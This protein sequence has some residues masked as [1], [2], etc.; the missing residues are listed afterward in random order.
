M[1]IDSIKTVLLCTRAMLFKTPRRRILTVVALGL[2]VVPA[3]GYAVRLALWTLPIFGDRSMTAPKLDAITSGTGVTYFHD[4]IRRVPWSIHVVKVERGR[5][6][7]AIDTTLGRA[8]R[9][10]MAT[11]SDQVASVPPEWGKPVAAINGDLY[12]NHPD[13]LGDPEGLQ[14]THGELVSGP[15]SNRVCFWLDAAGLPHRSNVVSRFEAIWP[16]GREVSLGLNQARSDDSAV[17][18][19]SVVGDS[20]RTRGGVELVLE[21]MGPEQWLPLE[22]GQTYTAKVRQANPAGNSPVTQSIMVL[23]LGP[24]LARQMPSLQAGETIRLCMATLPDLTGAQ[25]ALGGAPTLVAGGEPREW[26]GLRLRHP[27]TAIG[28]ND[29]YLFLVEVDGRQLRLSAGMT[30]AELADYMVKLGCQEAMNLDGGGSATCWVSGRVVNSPS[31]GRE[32]PAANALVVLR[33]NGSGPLPHTERGSV[34]PP[35]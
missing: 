33:R 19:T 28:W 16:N 34:L 25:T 26:N 7:L 5:G 13:Y 6:N 21:R 15:S 2:G 11:V 4:E 3:L 29:R 18:Y 35:R 8:G 31:Q 10:G 23:S 27:R 1:R 20:T 24:A 17:L 9:V 32:R 30:L 14:I 22:I 12:E